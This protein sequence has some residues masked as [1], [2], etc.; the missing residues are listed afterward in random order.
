MTL[1]PRWLMPSV[2]AA[3]LAMAALAPAP[4]RA[5]DDLVRVLV[6]VAD[7]IYRSGQPYYRHGNYGYN[8][9]IIVV[10]DRDGHRRYYRHVPRQY[11]RSGPP[12]GVAHGY[13]RNRDVR[14][15]RDCNRRG[16]C[17]VRY[18]DP[19]HDARADRRYDRRDY[20]DYRVRHD[21]RRDRGRDR[22]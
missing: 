17:V 21:G 14:L 2:L 12:Y 7:V 13:Y 3:G 22:D 8:D 10:R 9:R 20:R 4:A 15:D 6:N 19:R 5:N 18:Y 11:R 16:D 1:T